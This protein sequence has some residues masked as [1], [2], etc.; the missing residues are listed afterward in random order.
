MVYVLDFEEIPKLGSFVNKFI[1][2]DFTKRKSLNLACKRFQRIYQEYNVEDQLIDCMIAFEA[3]F[4]KGERRA[5]SRGKIIAIAC[6]T[7]LGSND[8]EREEIKNTL[9]MAYSMRNSIVH[10]GECRKDVNLFEVVEDVIEY[11]RQSIIKFLD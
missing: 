10:G 11:L 8:E 3:L 5:S 6:S 1:N 4:L 9:S 2:I 7:L